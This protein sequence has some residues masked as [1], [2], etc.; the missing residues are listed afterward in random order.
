VEQLEAVDRPH[1]GHPQL[2]AHADSAA[3]VLLCLSLFACVEGCPAGV[4]QLAL[5][6]GATLGAPSSA[7]DWVLTQRLECCCLSV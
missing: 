6:H 2:A 3:D 7:A 5:V 1:L 4:V